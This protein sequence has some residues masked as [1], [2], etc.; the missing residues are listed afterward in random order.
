LEIPPEIIKKTPSA[1]LWPGQTDEDELGMKYDTLDQILS[2]FEQLMLPNE[3]SREFN[4]P[5]KVIKKVENMLRLSEHKRTG[6]MVFKMGSRTPG[7]D[8]RLSATSRE[9]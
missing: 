6:P 8:W 1:G 3:I 7:F 9:K 4:I 2:S 5:L